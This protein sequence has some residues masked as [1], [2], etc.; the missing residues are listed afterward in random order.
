VRSR[1]ECSHEGRQYRIFLSYSHHDLSIA[2][3]I[4][5]ILKDNGLAPMWDEN[6]AY[7]RGFHV[8]F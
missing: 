8:R 6:F 5:R 4:D 1:P 3:A 2:K 7:G